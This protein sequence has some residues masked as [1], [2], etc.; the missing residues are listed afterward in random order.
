MKVTFE[1]EVDG[2]L[3]E[4]AKSWGLK[5]EDLVRDAMEHSL[6]GSIRRKTDNLCRDCKKP[7]EST[8][9]PDLRVKNSFPKGFCSCR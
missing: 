5:M 2:K 7:I 9:P 1:A 4:E 8:I 6:E 3:V